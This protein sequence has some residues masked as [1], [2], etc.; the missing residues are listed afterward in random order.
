MYP[1]TSILIS[2]PLSDCEERYSIN[3]IPRSPILIIKA[4]KETSP[5]QI[6]GC[7]ASGNGGLRFE[8]KG[9]RAFLVY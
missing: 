7:R 1:K 9:S 6:S 5:I 8:R 3:N 2:K 4:P